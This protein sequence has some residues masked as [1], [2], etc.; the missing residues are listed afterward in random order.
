MILEKKELKK[1]EL[2]IANN[3]LVSYICKLIWVNL[4]RKS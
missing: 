2:I 3:L 4:W 1:K